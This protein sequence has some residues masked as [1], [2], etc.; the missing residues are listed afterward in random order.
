MTPEDELKALVYAHYQAYRIPY[1]QR[2]ILLIEASRDHHCS[3]CGAL[4]FRGCWNKTDISRGKDEIRLNKLPHEERID[5]QQA[6]M[7]LWRR[8][9]WRESLVKLTLV[10]IAHQEEEKNKRG[11]QKGSEELP[12]QN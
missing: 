7:A 6:K 4:P 11:R 10:R 3:S 2:K 12:L 5:W 9:M 8:G 1:E